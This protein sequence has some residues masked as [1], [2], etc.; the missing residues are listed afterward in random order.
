MK[1]YF[2]K[3][4]VIPVVSVILTA[5]IFFSCNKEDNTL[6]P[7]AGSDGL[8]EIMIQDSSFTPK[9]TWL[10]GYVTVLGVN[11]GTH[12]AIDSSLIWL[13]YKADN[14]IH[15]PV[16][17]GVLPA[18]AQDL[19]SQYNGSFLDTLIEDSTYTFWIMKA[20]NWSK[21]SSEQNKIIVLDSSI[22]NYQSNGDTVRFSPRDYF[23]ITQNLDNYVNIYNIESRG[24]LGTISVEQPRT[25]NNPLISWQITQV[26]DS[27]IAA[28]G[29]T[30]GSQY[31]GS[32]IA[33]EV[34]SVSDSAG[35]TYYGK[36]NVIA[37]PVIAGQDLPET[38]VFTPYIEG[39]LKRNTSYYIWIANRF[40]DGE[41]RTRVTDYYAYV[42]FN[43]N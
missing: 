42:T 31:N 15:F 21:I 5:M 26:Q 43:T 34:Y 28:I 8:S 41:G 36:K 23:Q 4:T 7:Y 37:S 3:L 16:Q 11:R 18:G 6:A 9:V 1:S 33:W 24:K 22:T 30:E 10:G 25:S 14:Q 27:L 32:A 38:F 39:G 19:T 2:T 13:I 40:W 35:G 20:E 12:A 29:I 17:Y